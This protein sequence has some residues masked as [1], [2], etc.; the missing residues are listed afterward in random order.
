MERGGSWVLSESSA[1]VSEVVSFKISSQV[2]RCPVWAAVLPI[3]VMRV[4]FA[5]CSSVCRGVPERISA[6]S[7]LCVCLYILEASPE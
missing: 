2:I 3:I 5:A 1:G 7:S 6:K 4:L